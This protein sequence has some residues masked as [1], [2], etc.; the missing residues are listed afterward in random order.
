MEGKYQRYVVYFRWIVGL[1]LLLLGL[2][3]LFVPFIPLGYIFLFAAFIIIGPQLPFYNRFINWII[4]RDHSGKFERV[5]KRL[6]A[7]DKL[8]EKK[9]E[10]WFE[11]ED[12]DDSHDRS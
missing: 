9:L 4:R 3:F 1:L 8:L 12:S 6:N 11:R 2:L 5:E 7:W 10:K